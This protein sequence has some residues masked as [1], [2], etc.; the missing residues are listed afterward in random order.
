MPDLIIRPPLQDRN[1]DEKRVD[2]GDVMV[3]SCT[4]PHRSHRLRPKEGN[5]VPDR[6]K[7]HR[8]DVKD[9]P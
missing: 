3:R 6:G 4:E 1:R 9:I 7:P 2:G 8:F 5:Q